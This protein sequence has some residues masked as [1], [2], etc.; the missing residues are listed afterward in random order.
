MKTTRILRIICCLLVSCEGGRTITEELPGDGTTQQDSAFAALP[1]CNRFGI[2]LLDYEVEEDEIKRNENF[3]SILQRRGVDYSI[4]HELTQK[5]TGVFDMRKLKAGNMYSIL[6][7]PESGDPGY[8][9]YEE[10]ERTHICFALR[11]SIYVSQYEIPVTVEE[12][13][14]EVVISVSLWED[15]QNAG[16]N[17]LIANSLSEVYAWTV[18]FFGLQKG[19]A[20]NVFY[21]ANILDGKE[22]EPGR[23][24]AASFTR[25][26][27]TQMAFRYV[28]DSMP[29]YWDIQGENLQKA[30]L[31]A[32]LRYSRVSSGFSYSRR[33]PITRIVRPHTGVDYAAPTGTP[34][35]SIGDGVV[36]ERKYT[37]GGGNTV[38]IKHNS[39]YTTAY[40]HLSKFAKGLSVG[41]RV[42]QAEVIGYVGST[43]SS[44]GPH[45]D[46]RV[47][48]NGKPINPL[49]MESPPAEPIK[50]ENKADF[51]QMTA[52]YRRSLI[53]GYYRDLALQIIE[54]AGVK[55]L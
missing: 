18:D 28:Q 30:F 25:S 19:D 40:L 14:A 41:K 10:N 49:K 12:R 45:L 24:V 3:A 43:G 48:K 34:V 50:A 46:F 32:P 17:P 33:H 38:R 1:Y 47:W 26:R 51:L 6:Y 7:L 42:S 29:G 53:P 11:D 13:Y 55:F 23:I 15:L 37:R 4:I 36:I 31:K 22:T 44:T 27:K 52:C 54:K 35:Q 2:P 9:I 8:M 20:F 5:A 39:V 16:Y 21:M